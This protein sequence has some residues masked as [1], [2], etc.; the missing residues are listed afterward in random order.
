MMKTVYIDDHFNKWYTVWEKPTH[1][2]ADIIQQYTR[3]M[4][5]QYN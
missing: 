4:A 2:M 1:N 5:V 3:T